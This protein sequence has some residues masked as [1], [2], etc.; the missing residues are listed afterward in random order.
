MRG[1]AASASRD[2]ELAYHPGREESG[3]TDT[4]HG[5]E[6]ITSSQR[7][8]FKIRAHKR[9]TGTVAGGV[10]TINQRQRLKTKVAKTNTSATLK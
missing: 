5:H 8:A 1:A 4:L 6:N 7:V 2:F 10:E 9:R 3:T